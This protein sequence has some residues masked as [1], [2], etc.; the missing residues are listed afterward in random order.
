M[1]LELYPHQVQASQAV[2]QM[3]MNKGRAAVILPTGTGKS[4]I[5]F[6]LIEQHP[7]SLFLWLGPS[8]YIFQTQTA[9]LRSTAPELSL[10]NVTFLTYAK[11]Y[12]ILV[13]G[14]KAE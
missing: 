2:S 4:Y 14:R 13:E 11:V 5:A 10:H 3:L 1:A 12:A 6:H 8:E 9:T 7:D